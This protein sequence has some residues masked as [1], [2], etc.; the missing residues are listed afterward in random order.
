MI[1]YCFLLLG[2]DTTLQRYP[3]KHNLFF[4]LFAIYTNANKLATLPNNVESKNKRGMEETRQVWVYAF[5]AGK[6]LQAGG[7][8]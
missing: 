4:Y 3:P 5:E 1:K 8:S 6:T 2:C 7:R